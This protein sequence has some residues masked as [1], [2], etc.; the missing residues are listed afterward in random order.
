M[1][2]Q[3]KIVNILHLKRAL[4][5]VWQSAPGWTLASAFLL[6]LQGSLPLASLYLMKLIVDSLTSGI[7]SA[8]KEAT[9]GYILFLISLAAGVAFLTALSRSVSGVVSEV[10]AALV[11]DHILDLLHAKSIE[12]DLEYYENP[13]YYD[14]LHRAQNDA[15]FRPTRIVNGLVQIGQSSLSLLAVFGLIASLSWIVAV[16]LTITAIPAALVRLIYS[17]RTYRWQRACTTKERK[18]WYFHWLLTGDSHAKE[19]R[20]FELGPLFMKRYHNLRKE[21]RSERL[22]ITAKRSAADLAAQTIG[23]AAIFGSLVFIALSAFQGKITLGDLVMYFGALQQGQSFLSSLLSGFAGLYED[24][25]FLTTFYEFLDLKPTVKESPNPM[26]VPEV[27]KD[28]ISLEHVGFYYP[29]HETRVLEDINLHINPGQIIALVGE[30]GSGKTTLV[31]LLCRLYDPTAGRITL[32]GTNLR[33]FR[34]SDLRK[35]I[36]VIFQDYTHYNLTAR[37][38]IWVGS[39]DTPIDTGNISL[40]AE[41]SGADS[42]IDK[43]D[44]GY[45][46]ILGKWFEDGAE[47]SIG[48][49]QKVALAR[50][51]FRESQ[52][53]ILDEPTSSLDPKAE[54]EVFKKFRQ[55]ASGRTAIIISHRLSTTRMADC[56]YFLKDGRILEKGNHKELMTL[57]GEYAQLFRTQSQ[58]Y[59]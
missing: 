54:D 53:L 19:I 1:N 31:K 11:S 40:A 29:G 43:L 12:A 18:A 50:A 38:N 28:G 8:N 58:H 59:N 56:I 20:L 26:Q 15:P 24:N 34:I 55:L 10:Q 37:E 42:V 27:M 3:E 23:I 36:S 39:V 22:S 4:L 25:L 2:L 30:N 17:D 51:F 33:D 21:L 6:V 52:L 46:T 13:K 57:D 49:W 47:L 44:K 48:Q 7:G 14:T 41:R 16:A 32:D 45:E 9:F 5:L 35:Q